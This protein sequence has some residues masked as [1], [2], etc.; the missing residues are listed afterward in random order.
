MIKKITLILFGGLLSLEVSAADSFKKISLEEV[1]RL[2][3]KSANVFI[4]DA[5]VESTRNNVGVVPTAQL[6]ESAVEMDPAKVLPKNKKSQ[7]V[8]YC[9]NQMCT[10]SHI[11]AEKAIKAGYTNVSVMVDGIY[12]WQKAGYTLKR[13]KPDFNATSGSEITPKQADQLVKEGKAV[14]VDLR[15]DE[16]RHERVP[17]ALWYPMSQFEDI[18]R[19]QK[20]A[21]QIP[22]EKLIVFHCAAGY[23]S[24][25]AATRLA[26]SGSKS[27]YFKGVDQWRQDG[28]PIEAK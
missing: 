12:G 1:N 14:I 11:A 10:A 6:L 18:E 19:W 20:F 21:A 15:E 27:Y 28:L 23:R 17:K 4:Y 5:N 9:A 22:K 7:L 2:I 24:Q 25:K 8:F 16:E 3:A 26:K 13:I